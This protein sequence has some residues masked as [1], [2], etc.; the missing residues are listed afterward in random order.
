ML[1]LQAIER[2]RQLKARYFRYLDTRNL[3]GLQ[4]CFCADATVDFS[5]PSYE[6]HFK[7]WVELEAFFKQAFSVTKYGMHN[8]HHPEICVEGDTATGLWYL[9]DLFLNEE[10]KTV[11]QGTAVYQDRYVRQGDDWLIQH[12]GYERMLEVLSPLPDDW[13]VNSRPIR[14]E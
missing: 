9:H 10:D 14:P 3:Q 8:G 7:G 12:S 11:L 4:T 2:I 6:I 5:S 13:Q 1:D